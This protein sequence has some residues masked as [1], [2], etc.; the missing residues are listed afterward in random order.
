MEGAMAIR[1][2]MT[3][4]VAWISP[5]ASVGEA[6]ERLSSDPAGVIC[7]LVG[8]DER[9]P[10]GIVTAVDILR[11]ALRIALHPASISCACAPGRSSLHAEDLAREALFPA[12]ACAAGATPVRAIMSSP[13][14]CVPETATPA[15][16]MDL[17]IGQKIES[18]P[19]LRGG[20]VVGI[21]H[22]R[23]LLRALSAAM[24][25]GHAA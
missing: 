18:L 4:D 15:Q 22:R 6:A 2:L 17:M 10:V 24:K 11:A 12:L 21:I 23:A 7:L 3:Q 9:A 14:R 13:V 25:H 16:V 20:C 19:V 5:E 1:E 8:S